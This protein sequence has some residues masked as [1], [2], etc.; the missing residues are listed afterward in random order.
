MKRL[1]DNG[2]LVANIKYEYLP[3]LAL[4][5]PQEFLGISQEDLRIQGPSAGAPSLPLTSTNKDL[6]YEE[7]E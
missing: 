4:G 1:Y 7:S 2:G 6:R 5:S 3:I